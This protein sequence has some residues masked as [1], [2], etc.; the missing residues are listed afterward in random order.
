MPIHKGQ[1]VEL[2]CLLKAG[3]RGNLKPTDFVEAMDKELNLNI[4]PDTVEIRRIG[5]YLA[6]N[7]KIQLPI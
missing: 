2:N 5:L 6:D 1:L 4:D 7:G 3:D